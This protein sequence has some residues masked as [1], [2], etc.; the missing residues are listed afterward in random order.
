[1]CSLAYLLQQCGTS[2]FEVEK[3]KEIENHRFV[4]ALHEHSTAPEIL[5]RA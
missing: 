1:M 2:T 3:G 4:A 5:V